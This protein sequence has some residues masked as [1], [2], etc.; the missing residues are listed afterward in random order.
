MDSLFD[1]RVM[2]QISLGKNWKNISQDERKSF[3][4]A[5]EKKL[6]NSFIEKL[7]LYNDQDMIINDINQIKKNRIE[8][9]TQLVGP[10]ENYPII[11]K[12]YKQKKTDNW[13]IYDINIIGVSIIHTYRKQFIAFLREKPIEELISNLNIKSLK[14]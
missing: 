14:K 3:V 5:F 7:D 13:L 9:L 4:L 6:K 2:S 11:Y 12:F 8:L 1:Y 10:E